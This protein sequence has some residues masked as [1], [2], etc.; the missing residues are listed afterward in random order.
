MVYKR[1][2]AMPLCKAYEYIN[3]RVKPEE[4]QIMSELDYAMDF[5]KNPFPKALIA[6]EREAYFVKDYPNLRLTFDSNVR[7]RTGDLFLEKGSEGKTIL[8]EGEFILEI[9]TD[10][11]MP[12]WMSK[13]INDL[14]IYPVSFSKYGTAYREFSVLRS[15]LPQVWCLYPFPRRGDRIWNCFKSCPS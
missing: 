12:T 14:E 7:Y 6:Y 15:K 4:S 2:V 1:R 3:S 5:Y 8:P 9:K 13:A 11:A 10:G